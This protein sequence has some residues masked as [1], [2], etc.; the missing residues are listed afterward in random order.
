MLKYR[1]KQ[2]FTLSELLVVVAIVGILV[3]ISIPVFASQREKA[4]RAVDMDTARKVKSALVLAYN[5]EEIQVPKTASSNGYGTWVML[6]NGTTEYAPQAY[7][8]NGKTV[9]GMWCGANKG[10]TVHGHTVDHDWTYNEKGEFISRMY[11]GYK[12]Q[13]GA[14][15]QEK[16]PSNLEKMLYKTAS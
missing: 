15:G 8:N 3:A 4:R 14:A 11:S 5:N 16:N 2:A 13:N 10:V 7:R 9:K 1:Q 12:N 6:C